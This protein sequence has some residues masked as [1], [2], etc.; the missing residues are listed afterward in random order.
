MSRKYRI[1]LHAVEKS[2]RSVQRNFDKINDSLSMRREPLRE[3]ILINMLEG[4]RYV[5]RLLEEG[6]RLLSREGLVHF[7]ELN[8]IVLCGPE[9][10]DTRKEYRQHIQA[11]TDRFYSQKD[12]SI[13][14]LRNW[15]AN[16]KKSSPWKRAAGAYVLHVSQ[17]QLF[18]EGN[19]RTGALL[20]SSILVRNGEPPF[21]LTVKNAKGY[22]DP[23]T[24][25]KMTHKDFL[26]KYYKLPKIT[27]KFAKFLKKQA[28]N[29]LLTKH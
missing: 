14:D 15:A 25:I 29:K 24:L 22:F 10:L 4:Y 5:N 16:H 3:S 19:H 9:N 21:V 27:K 6:I 2:L 26:G 17:P 1:D 7:L 28:N 8:H 12:F 11:T 18:F 13:R 20:M 23:S